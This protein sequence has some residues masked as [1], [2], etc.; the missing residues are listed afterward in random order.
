[1]KKYTTYVIPSIKIEN[2]DIPLQR[3]NKKKVYASPVT[4]Y[5]Q[6]VRYKDS[7]SKNETGNSANKRERD[8]AFEIRIM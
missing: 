1:M 5:K 4:L 8:K 3:K 6:D 2:N 7:Y